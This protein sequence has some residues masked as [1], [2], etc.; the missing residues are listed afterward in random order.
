M[1]KMSIRLVWVIVYGLNKDMAVMAYMARKK[2]IKVVCNTMI[3]TTTTTTKTTE[4]AMT[5]TT[6]T[7][8]MKNDN[9]DNNNYNNDNKS[10]V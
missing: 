6:M 1:I 5:A 10:V 8:M 2:S 7:P 3:A 4:T 9:N